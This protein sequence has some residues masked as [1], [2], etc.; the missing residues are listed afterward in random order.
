MP[1]APE[2]WGAY[3][4]KRWFPGLMGWLARREWV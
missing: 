2:A 1:V 4:V 3:Y